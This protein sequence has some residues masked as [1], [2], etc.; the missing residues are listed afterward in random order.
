MCRGVPYGDAGGMNPRTLKLLAGGYLAV[1]LATV[2]AIVAMR[3]DTALVTDAVWTRGTLVAI[4][5]VLTYLFAAQ[6]ARGNGRGYLRLRIVALI[7]LVAIVTI[8]AVPG[9]FPLWMKVEQGVCGLL[10]LGLRPWSR[11]D[12]TRVRS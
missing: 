12:L 9:A 5:S 1:N 8:I 6:A 3:H 2:V 11:L 10:L 4:S 7:Q